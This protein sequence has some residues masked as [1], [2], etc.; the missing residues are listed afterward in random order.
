MRS[1]VGMHGKCEENSVRPS[2]IASLMRPRADA[3]HVE[4]QG[5]RR[6]LYLARLY[7]L[8]HAAASP[9]FSSRHSQ[10]RLGGTCCRVIFEPPHHHISHYRVIQDIRLNASSIRI[11]LRRAHVSLHRVRLPLEINLRRAIRAR[12]TDLI[13]DW[14]HCD[15]NTRRAKGCTSPITKKSETRFNLARR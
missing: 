2:R 15:T 11:H 10:A 5:V 12:I 13:A 6:D 1:G 14:G 3:C 8:P 9:R 4:I 7:R